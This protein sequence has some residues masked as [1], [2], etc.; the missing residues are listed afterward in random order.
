M[1][2]AALGL[3]CAACLVLSAGVFA[4][5]AAVQALRFAGILVLAVIYEKKKACTN[6][7]QAVILILA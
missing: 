4:D 2:R 6:E 1:G 3:S 5:S 7:V